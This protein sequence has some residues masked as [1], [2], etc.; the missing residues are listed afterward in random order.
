MENMGIAKMKEELIRLNP[1]VKFDVRDY[2]VSPVII[3]Y[4]N[5]AGGSLN[6][7][8]GYYYNGKNSITN[9]HNTKTG[10]YESFL[11]R[12]DTDHFKNRPTEAKTGKPDKAK[13]S[14]FARIFAR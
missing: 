14:L 7:P 4:G 9:K 2:K 1:G 13:K 8:D 5:V 11:Y 10:L 3:I 12:F 6:L